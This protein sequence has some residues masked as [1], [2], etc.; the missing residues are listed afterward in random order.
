MLLVTVTLIP[1]GYGPPEELGR[2]IIANDGTGDQKVGNYV[3]R[4]GRK[5]QTDNRQIYQKPQRQGEVKNHRRLSLSV[6]TLVAKAL[7]VVGFGKEV[8][9]SSFEQD[10]KE[11]ERQLLESAITAGK[12]LEKKERP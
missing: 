4:V 6:W 7:H 3:V 11:H 12:E 8:L 1:G 10:Q 9:D 5:G 2:I